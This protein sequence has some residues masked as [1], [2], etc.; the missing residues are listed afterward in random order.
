MRKWVLLTVVMGFISSPITTHA[1]SKRPDIIQTCVACHGPR[2]IS[3][4]PQ[5]PNLAGQHASYLRKQLRDYKAG[6]YRDTAMMSGI[7]AGLSYQE[8]D[9]IAT[10]YAKLTRGEGAT[11]LKYRA[12]GERL[13]RGG[14][15]AKGITACIACHGPKGTGNAEAGFPVVAGQRAEY[16][17]QQLQAFKSKSRRN[18][19]NQIMQDICARMSPEDMVAVAY[20]MQGLY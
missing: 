18:D 2:G 17:I 6:K 5:W 14:D 8:I 3:A 11:P 1:A 20:Y 16:T 9:L 19:L 15:F 4:D 12:L 7:A 10:Y 13:Y